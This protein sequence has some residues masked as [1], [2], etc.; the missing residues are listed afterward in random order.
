MKVAISGMNNIDNPGPGVPVVRGLKDSGKFDGEII[1]L[2]YDALEPG[3]Y[4][5]D[6][7]DNN[8]L[9]PYPSGGLDTYF[10]RLANINRQEGIDVIIPTLDAELYAFSKLEPRLILL[11]T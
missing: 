2:I 5:S 11:L 9:I 10:D 7:S 1:G 6:I 3:M 4:M 8:Y